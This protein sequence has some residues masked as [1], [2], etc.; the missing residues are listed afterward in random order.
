MP[1]DGST[2]PNPTGGTAPDGL[3][4][5]QLQ[6]LQE[7]ETAIAR[8][9]EDFEEIGRRLHSINNGRLYR[10]VADTFEAY[11]LEQWTWIPQTCYQYIWAYEVTAELR[12]A[13]EMYTRIYIPT[14][15]S[16]ALQLR[17]L[18][19]NQRLAVAREL[20]NQDEGGARITTSLV[21]RII[22]Q[23]T[24]SDS[25][26]TS[27]SADDDLPYPVN[28]VRTIA[29]SE[30]VLFAD[31]QPDEQ[32]NSHLDSWEEA[33]EKGMPGSSSMPDGFHVVLG[34]SWQPKDE[35]MATRTAEGWLVN[36]EVPLPEQLISGI[37]QCGRA[38]DARQMTRTSTFADL[39]TW[40]WSPVLRSLYAEAHDLPD[41]QPLPHAVFMPARL[42]QPQ[43]TPEPKEG[44]LEDA[45]CQSFVFAC[46]G[47]DLFDALIPDEVIRMVV[48][49]MQQTAD[50]R[51]MLVTHNPERLT[52]YTAQHPLP[53]NVFI[54]MVA[55]DAAGVA[56]AETA[57]SGVQGGVPWIYVQHADAPITLSPGSA[58][59]WVVVEGAAD[60]PAI[61]YEHVAPLLEAPENQVA[62]LCRR[63]LLRQQQAWPAKRPSQDEATPNG[64]AVIRTLSDRKPAEHR[65]SHEHHASEQTQ[66]SS[67]TT[68]A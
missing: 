53:A 8:S 63:P 9:L 54:G 19:P 13:R 2:T 33:G 28:A 68:P 67:R 41:E 38:G 6:K 47:V 32:P 65:A 58:V 10:A 66:H 48:G 36:W 60:K 24:G 30:S 22:G 5:E 61:P 14:L 17:S 39:A 37:S 62:V 18:A 4:P 64:S 52:A 50:W 40:S 20:Y 26:A 31:G 3:T 44:D 29:K 57:L 43:N 11:C 21:R 56:G 1:H 34:A 55:E 7:H 49:H 25:S 27:S 23:V 12:A 35:S 15:K 16:H 42:P 59:R 45:L 51:F 46:P